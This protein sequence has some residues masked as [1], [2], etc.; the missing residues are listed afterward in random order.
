MPPQVG[1]AR[2]EAGELRYFVVP[3][4]FSEGGERVLA[5]D[6]RGPYAVDEK[7]LSDLDKRI[8]SARKSA[9]GPQNQPIDDAGASRS[10][11]MSLG[12]RMSSDLV[13]GV[14]V[15]AAIGW[16][17]DWVFGTS[18]FGLIIFLGLGTVAGVRNLLRTVRQ[19]AD[20]DGKDKDGQ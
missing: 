6:K 5:D 8:Q 7:A 14:L 15:G 3:R 11:N 10:S 12:L 2:L 4:A 1:C 19:M 16:G 9:K 20:E 17:L 18:P 13:A